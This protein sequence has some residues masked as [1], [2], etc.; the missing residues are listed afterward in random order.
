[1]ADLFSPTQ[2]LPPDQGGEKPVIRS[3]K[4]GR[5]PAIGRLPTLAERVADG[6]VHVVGVLFGLIAGGLL[7]T[8]APSGVVAALLVYSFGLL[9]MLGFSATYNLMPRERQMES[10]LRRLDHAAIFFLI[11][12]ICTPLAIHRLS[13]PLGVILL[14]VLWAAAIAGVVIKLRVRP[15]TRRV[16]TWPYLAVGWLAVAITIPLYH[17]LVPRNFWLLMGGAAVYS[18]GTVAF[19]FYWIPFHRAIWHSLVLLA[20]VLQFACIWG[21][22]VR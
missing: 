16:S 19:R 6:V 21:E 15:K 3:R 5:H 2:E 18:F 7:L 1:M 14:A 12:A 9:S 4:R 8:R 20:T 11:A 13:Q 22:F 17:V 10:V